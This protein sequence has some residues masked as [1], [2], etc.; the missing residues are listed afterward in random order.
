[1]TEGTEQKILTVQED[2]ENCEKCFYNLKNCEYSTHGFLSTNL[3][4]RDE[5][6]N[7]KSLRK[8]EKK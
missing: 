4:P 3:L 6:G 7:C 2:L 1:M 5:E 8:E